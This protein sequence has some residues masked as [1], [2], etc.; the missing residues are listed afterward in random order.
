MMPR[1]R[2]GHDFDGRSTDHP[3]RTIGVEVRREQV[4]WRAPKLDRH[5][6]AVDRLRSV[7]NV[8]RDDHRL[9]RAND[10]DGPVSELHARHARPDLVERAPEG[11]AP[12]GGKK[13][14]PSVCHAA[15]CADPARCYLTVDSPS[16]NVGVSPN[17]CAAVG[18]IA[19]A[20]TPQRPPM[21]C[22]SSENRLVRVVLF[23]SPINATTRARSITGM[24]TICM[25]ARYG[26]ATD[27]SRGATA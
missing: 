8:R 23:R 1:F 4:E 18:A 15:N 10:G 2:D 13:A 22:R 12:L 6:L 7:L 25:T 21:N 17:R 19:A 26:R 20:N 27:L 11:Q 24:A 14:R 3:D 5:S 9:A 16:N